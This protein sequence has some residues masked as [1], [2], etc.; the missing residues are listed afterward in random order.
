MA[1]KIYTEDDDGNVIGE[2]DG[3]QYVNYAKPDRNRRRFFREVF[4]ALIGI[5]GVIAL[6]FS[7]IFLFY[8]GGGALALFLFGVL[9]ISVSLIG[10]R[11]KKGERN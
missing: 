3:K 11:S 8:D 1:L 10:G 7:V 6:L 9:F 5:K 4:F 2:T